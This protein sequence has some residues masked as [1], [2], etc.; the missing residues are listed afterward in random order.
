[1]S[2]IDQFIA[3]VMHAC[4]F[5]RMCV[6]GTLSKLKPKRMPELELGYLACAWSMPCGESKSGRDQA[7]LFNYGGD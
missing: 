3:T 7:K 4:C 1:M 2:F 5:A 6:I